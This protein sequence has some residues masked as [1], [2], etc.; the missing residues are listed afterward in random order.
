MTNLPIRLRE[1]LFKPY[2]WQLDNRSQQL[3]L[4]G[5]LALL[6]TLMIL[7][8]EVRR[9]GRVA[10][11]SAVPILYVAI[12]LLVVYSVSAGNAGTAFRYRTHVVMML[13]A[14]VVVMRSRDPASTVQVV[15]DSVGR[16]PVSP[17]ST[18]APAI[19]PGTP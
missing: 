12:C 15:D 14:A 18:I 17:G 13:V 16:V 4:L 3:G 6:A 7:T 19:P 9:N 1:V 11:G 5:T 8:A 2:P 10:L